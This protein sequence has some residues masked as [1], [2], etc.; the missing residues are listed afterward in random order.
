M[1]TI[2][3]NADPLTLTSLRGRS[4]LITGGA[5]GIGRDLAIACVKA[6]AT[7]IVGDLNVDGLM[8]TQRLC[9]DVQGKGVGKCVPFLEPCDVTSP[10]KQSELFKFA[11][12]QLEGSVPDVVVANAGVN[13]LGDY[14]KVKEKGEYRQ[15]FSLGRSRRSLSMRLG[16]PRDKTGTKGTSNR[17][18]RLWED[19]TKGRRGCRSKTRVAWASAIVFSLGGH[20]KA[21]WVVSKVALARLGCA[22]EPWGMS[23]AVENFR[24]VHDNWRARQT[25]EPYEP[26]RGK[27][28]HRRRLE[29]A[30]YPLAV[31][32]VRRGNFFLKCKSGTMA[33]RR[34]GW[35]RF[36]D[37]TSLSRRGKSRLFER[38]KHVMVFARRWCQEARILERRANEIAG[39][40]ARTLTV[41]DIYG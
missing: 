27:N 7:V 26:S 24:R 34:A 37:H 19:D 12:K 16:I 6:G 21:I 32:P 35:A 13:E 10:A 2:P 14:L 38:R 15:R 29:R 1:K 20:S 4:V 23:P 28:R 41:Y 8:G 11:A 36:S 33:T 3:I 17:R 25:R 5:S 22:G 30:R 39:R 40:C 18:S 9:Q 31:W